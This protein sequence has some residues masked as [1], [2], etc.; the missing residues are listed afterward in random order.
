MLISLAILWSPLCEGFPLNWQRSAIEIS[1]KEVIVARLL[2]RGESKFCDLISLDNT[3]KCMRYVCDIKKA[4]LI[5]KRRRIYGWVHCSK[6]QISAR[7][8]PQNHLPLYAFFVSHLT[9]SIVTVCAPIIIILDGMH[10]D[11]FMELKFTIAM[12]VSLSLFRSIFSFLFLFFCKWS[13]CT[14]F[15]LSYVIGIKFK[16]YCGMQIERHFQRVMIRNE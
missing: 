13:L 9:L 3:F 2:L 1:T 15:W 14:S 11:F 4:I 16:V 10:S 8:A 12:P 5:N 7:S 6:M